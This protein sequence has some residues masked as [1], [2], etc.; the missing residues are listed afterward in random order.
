ML[1]TKTKLGRSVY[2]QAIKQLQTVM[3]AADETP[4]TNY[5]RVVVLTIMNMRYEKVAFNRNLSGHPF[6]VTKEI[7]QDAKREFQL[8]T[9]CSFM[10]DPEKSIEKYKSQ[11]LE[12]KHE[13]LWQ[14]IWSRHEGKEFRDFVDL[15]ARRL[16]VNNLRSYIKGKKGVDFGCGNG[17]FA[18]ALLE[19]GAASVVGIDFGAKA[20]RF[21]TKMA[22]RWGW[23]DKARFKVDNVA[24]TNLPNEHFDFAVSN[25]VFHHLRKEEVDKALKEVAR[26]LKPGGWLWYYVDGKDAISMDLWDASVE[27]L[28]NVDI[29]FIENILKTMNVS[30][31]KMVFIMDGLSATYIH[32]TWEDVVRQLTRFG[33]GNFR[34]LV[35]GAPTDFDLDVITQDPYGREKFGEGDLRI[36]CQKI[37]GGS[38]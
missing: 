23:Q 37:T 38:P 29:L 35:G 10:E 16:D 3:A 9:E 36:W 8:L 13:E 2:R 12:E 20:V 31:P 17:S 28:K 4:F 27:I 22:K 26:V 24:A 14:E 19:R 5:V 25:G 33:F 1:T 21:A 32:T 6:T 34:R 15:K 11:I 30:R 18:L 7:I